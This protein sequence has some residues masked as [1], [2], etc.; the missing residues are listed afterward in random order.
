MKLSSNPY[1]LEQ[2]PEQ[3]TRWWPVWI[4]FGVMALLMVLTV[5]PS[6]DNLTR[7]V[8]M[9][10]GPAV[11]LA[12]F[13]LWLLL[14]SRL[15]RPL[16]MPLL[17]GFVAVP[18]VLG[19]FIDETAGVALWIYAFPAAMLTSVM[20]LWLGR[21]RTLEQ[22][23]IFALAPAVLCFLAMLF[24]RM[25]GFTGG[26]LPQLAWRFDPPADTQ[27]TATTETVASETGWVAETLEWPEF[28]GAQRNG[29]ATGVNAGQDWTNNPPQEL[30]KIPIGSGWG[31]FALVSGRLFT[32]E[33]RGEQ[34]MI[35]C[36]DAETGDLIWQ[37]GLELRF[38]EVVSGPGPRATPTY[39]DGKIYALGAMGIVTALR[40]EDGKHLWSYSMIDEVGAEKL[41]WGHSGSPL[42]I[43]GKVVVYAEGTGNNGLIALDAFSGKKVWAVASQANRNNYASPVRLQLAGQELIGMTDRDG[44]FAVDTNGALQFRY[45]PEDWGSMPPYV[46]IQQID[47]ES[48]IVSLGDGEGLVRLKVTNLDNWR[49]EQLWSSRGLKPSFNAFLYHKGYLYGFDQNIFAC[50]DAKTGERMWKRGRYGFGQAV[51]LKD[52]DQLLIL[53]ESG[54]LVLLA[55]DP[56]QHR[57]LGRIPVINGKTWNHPIAAG[58]RI[59]VRN[60]V[61]AAALTPQL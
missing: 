27:L 20:G 2:E 16:T 14:F 24:I 9:M 41:M 56:Q 38:A 3:P 58:G 19:L 4:V 48:L 10:A 46:A 6:I 49:V 12:L 15:P 40:A 61:E 37:F 18:A 22:R 30:W 50:V 45:T 57:E 11:T 53:A 39:A 8:F 7:F 25:D 1:I 52:Q 17:I 59:Y 5:T 13:I 21:G 44:V 51:L 28:R 42:V 35:S 60:G 26:Y 31:S 47:P 23:R 36:Y 43:D 54:E 32:Q 34:E 29:V 33:Q 55:A